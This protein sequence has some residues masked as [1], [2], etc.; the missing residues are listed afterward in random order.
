MKD[1][2]IGGV[3]LYPWNKISTWVKSI[4]ATGFDG[5]VVLLAY[6]LLEREK[7][8]D[9]CAKYNVQVLEIGHDS[10][11]Q[12]INHT[13]K[14]NYTQSHQMR[15]F[16]IWQY[17]RDNRDVEYR[18]VITTDVRDVVF[19]SNPFL[20]LEGI[21]KVIASFEGMIYE[22]E[23]FNPGDLV[24]GIGP[25]MWEYANKWN[26]YNVGVL[27]GPARKIEGLSFIIY[28]MTFGRPI[29][30]DQTVYNTLVNE[31]APELFIHW[32][33]ETPWA[34]QCAL[35]MEPSRDHI[36]H[37]FKDPMPVVKDGL[38]Y[39]ADGQLFPIVHQY[40]RV[41]GLNEAIAARFA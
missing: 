41:P 26:I 3:D 32:G 17:L 40:D 14:N 22:D 6:R 13:D 33:H 11:G 9:E 34:C 25:L 28:S 31:M 12:P 20:K 2:L 10:F 4:R 37:N 16:H 21:D 1:L 30:S 29:P 8:I 36:R 35:S 18:N 23:F 38:V 39:T 5:D 24:K 15:F 27:G 19:Q 7:T